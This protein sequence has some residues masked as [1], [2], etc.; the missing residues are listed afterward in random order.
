MA[1]QWVVLPSRDLSDEMVASTMVDMTN[2]G[3]RER[4]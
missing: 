1:L 2:G 3:H 4:E